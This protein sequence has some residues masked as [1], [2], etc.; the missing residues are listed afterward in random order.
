MR[1]KREKGKLRRAVTVHLR[2]VRTLHKVSPRFFPLETASGLLNAIAPYVTVF[3]S[4]R[5]RRP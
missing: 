3:F 1:E 2:A 5:R 4:A